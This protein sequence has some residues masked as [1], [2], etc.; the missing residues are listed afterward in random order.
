MTTT[1]PS[2]SALFNLSLAISAAAL[3]FAGGPALSAT[4]FTVTTT[5][6]SGAG[7]LRQ[8]I[9]DAN[10]AAGADTIAFGIG[11]SGVQ[12]I[13]LASALPAITSPVTIDGYTQT[14]ALANTHDTSQGL[15]TVLKIEVDGAAL[16]AG[17]ICLDVAASDTT[18]KGLVIHGCDTANVRLQNSA[19]NFVL[20]GCFLGTDAA[21]TTPVAEAS[22]AQ[23]TG[24]TPPNVRIGGTTPAAR[25]LISGGHDKIV[26]GNGAGGPAGVTIQGNL[27][28]PD[29]TGTID[30]ADTGHGITLTR[31]TNVTIG[32]ASAA[33]RNVVS[34]NAGNGLEIDG[35]PATNTVVQGNYIG[36]DVTGAAPLGNGNRGIVLD[37]NNVIVG[38]SA[39]GA[40]NV[41]SANGAI[42]IV[43]GSSNVSMVTIVQGN[44]IGTD[45]SGTIPLGNAD[46]AIHVGA[47]DNVIGGTGAGEGNV[48]A[49]TKAT[50]GT[51][52]GVYL[53]FSQGNVI[54]GNRIFGN[55]GLGIDVMPAGSPDGVTPNDPLDADG[56][57]GNGLQNFPLF[58]SVTTG[59]T[60]HVQGVLH[61]KAGTTYDLDFYADA[62]SNFPREFLEGEEWIGTTQV[63]TDGSGDATFDAV[64][65]VATAATARITATATDPN[66]NTSE[67][68]QGLAFSASPASGPTAGGTTVTLHGTD[69]ASGL[70]VTVGGLPATA[71]NV[72]T[73]TTATFKTPALGAGLANDIAV[74]NADGTIGVLLKAFVTDFLDVPPANQFHAYV[75]KLVSN[76]ITA[77]VGGG[78]YGVNDNTLRQQMAVFLLKG[79]HGLC[80]TPPPCSGTFP[81]V[82]CPSTFANWIEALAAEGIT[83]GCGGG[84]FCPQNPVRRDQMAVF[85]LK[86]EHGSSYAPPDCAGT[87]ADVACPSTFANWI[88]QLA[89]E[90]ITGGCGGGNYCPLNNN[91][92]GQMA[93]F[94]SKTFNLP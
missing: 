90:Q 38:G 5:S 26:L 59:A 9:L 19:S 89:A 52:D 51:G 43:L 54:R 58:T 85:L 50:G 45:S 49:Y 73:A 72:S 91:T 29:V 67:F 32:G 1:G 82:P 56:G 77:G 42:G 62:C 44:F 76:G 68:S 64:L 35:N 34:G 83:G 65:P 46:R 84:N 93:V 60:T 4:T 47:A 70:A 33:S 20:E 30:L 14:G 2:R 63:T 74:V 53:P 41:I 87:F 25:N 6:D 88:E 79:K 39:A 86:A 17:S 55:A 27:V 48:I 3:L 16:G 28:G 37:S 80:Y 78:L 13:A 36:V 18:I 24:V 22:G 8:A 15:N 75:A 71:V 81:D 10:G 69:L 23:I 92:R 31:A 7:S 57:G 12:T 21:G 40:G 94:I 66:G 61:S 11:G